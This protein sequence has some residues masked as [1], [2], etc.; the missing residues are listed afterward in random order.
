MPTADSRN[1]FEPARTGQLVIQ[2]AQQARSQCICG[3]DC[4]DGAI[5][6]TGRPC[7]A[8][9][10]REPDT[11]PTSPLITGGTWFEATGLPCLVRMA[12]PVSAED[13]VAA[14]YRDHSRLLDADLETD[15]EIWSSIAIVIVQDGLYQI[16]RTADQICKQE[17]SGTLEAPDW[18]TYCRSR[19]AAVV[20]Q[21]WRDRKYRCPCGYATNDMNAFDEHLES[22]EGMEPE[23]S[24]ALDGWML[25][26]LLVCQSTVGT[27]AR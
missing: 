12:L 9:S 17:Q 13:M 4:K 22:T 1:P 25:E 24:E 8:E 3:G 2:A 21:T 7:R 19:V 6:L 15:E 16:W 20:G 5:P 26:Q 23:H 18:L 11:A 27:A 14:L 10:A